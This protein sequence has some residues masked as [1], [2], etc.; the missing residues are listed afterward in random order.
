MHLEKQ[1][2]YEDIAVVVPVYKTLS[3]S[4]IRVLNNINRVLGNYRRIIVTPRHLVLHTK[5]YQFLNGWGQIYF[6]DIFFSSIKGYNN[7]LLSKEFYLAFK[8]K[9]IKN[10]LI[11]Q[12]D[13]FVFKDE[14]SYWVSKKYAYIGAPW[15]SDVNLD[16]VL[17]SRWSFVLNFFLITN[18]VFFNKKDWKVGNGGLSIRNIKSSLRALLLSKVLKKFNLNEDVVWSIVVPLF[19]PF[20]KIPNSEE[21]YL[22][23]IEEINP[24]KKF[25]LPFGVHA[26]EKYGYDIWSQYIITD[27]VDV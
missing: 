1:T 24:A 11:H 15:L 26:W 6:D 4:D 17:S 16:K 3:E 8:K 12:L 20:F 2:Q 13:A 25:C 10:I 14:L 18:R 22:F 27:S 7:L 9:K 19:Y 21:A 5:N 23:S